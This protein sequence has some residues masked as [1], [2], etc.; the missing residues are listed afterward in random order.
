MRVRALLVLLGAAAVCGGPLTGSLGMG[1]WQQVHETK[2]G[3]APKPSIANCTWLYYEQPLDHFAQ[4]PSPYTFQ[5]RYCLYDKFWNRASRVGFNGT[6]EQAPIF[7]YT[8]NES[9]VDE[10]VNNTGLMWELGEKMGALIVFAEHR[11][12]GD[13]VPKMHDV[14]YCIS[15]CT[16][17]QA[18]AD[19]AELIKYLKGVY[20]TNA[21]VI[22]FGG[23][24]G[25]MLTGW[26]RIKYPD[27]IAGAIAGSAPVNGFPSVGGKSGLDA[28]SAVMGNGIRAKGGA[29][30]QCFTN[31][32]SLW[33]LMRAV[34]GTAWG[35][36]R[37]SDSAQRCSLTDTND[38]LTWGQ[39]P[40][41]YMAEGDF[42]FPSTYI[43]YSVLPG[44]DPLPAWPMRVACS[45]GL[46]DD[47]GIKIEGDVSE[48]RYNL[49][50]GKLRVSVDW[51]DM[52]SNV[53]D[54]SH[55]DIEST[56]V[57]DLVEAMTAAASVWYNVSGTK[58][59]YGAEEQ[60]Y[61][62]WRSTNPHQPVQQHQ[63]TD[64]T[65]CNSCPVCDNCPPCPLCEREAPKGCTYNDTPVVPKLFAWGP[66]CCN[67]DLYL[68]NLYVQGVGRD[69]FWPPNVPRDYTLESVVG[70]HKK[71]PGCAGQYDDQGLFGSP[72]YK[73]AWGEWI[74]SYYHSVNVSQYSN[75]VWS[76]GA[77]DPWAGAGVYGKGGSWN[78][79]T[80]QNVT[81]DG[82]S[83]ALVVDEGAHHLDLF[84]ATDSDPPS[85]LKVREVEEQKIREWSQQH[86]DS[87]RA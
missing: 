68:A 2:P 14:E 20:T 33:P 64:T 85:V 3:A 9:P 11:Y 44:Q 1:R 59:C 60:E 53:A 48:V 65:T 7:F 50:L 82:S 16:S 15:F 12:E 38:V 78:G 24:Y 47:F 84:F 83:V 74:T 8:G 22:A 61:P 62:D 40:W 34:G 56:R 75:I 76:N 32:R 51:S 86:Y 71:T 35:K 5:Q 43:T 67:E 36:Q 6:A 29:P 57:F 37:I 27:V 72:I 18:L 25:G 42:P 41:F 70:P 21:P 13:S 19:F 23:S 39:G 79:P 69:M 73:D 54:L 81:D 52:E 58:T 49:T 87:L 66:I 31:L 28:S 45:K 46:S 63:P 10:Y 30:E 26:M 55:D 77:L 4:T 17:A 80:V